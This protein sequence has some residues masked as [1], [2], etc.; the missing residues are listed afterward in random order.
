MRKVKKIRKRD[1]V[2]VIIPAFRQEK[3]IVRNIRR[4]EKALR[5]LSYPFELII[6]V[7]GMVDQT[8]SQAKKL[9]SRNIKV[10]GYESNRGKG[11]AVRYG[12]VRSKGSIIG[13][14]DSGMDINPNGLSI[15]VNELKR[16]KMDIMDIIIGSKR[17]AQSKVV[18]PMDRKILSVLSQLFIRTLFGLNVKDTQVGLKFFRREVLEDVLPR[19]LV[20]QFAFDIEIL[21]VAFHLG[22]RKIKEAPI[23]LTLN[24][25]ESIVSQNLFKVIVKTLID[26]LAIFYRLKILHYYDDTS[27]RKW[28]F[29]PELNFRINVV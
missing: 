25:T 8:F 26:T 4:I 2:S 14:I 1:L 20:K 3:T 5:A 15:P 19:L 22:Y 6:V 18:Y 17:H 27:K 28:K 23:E 12:M 29:D 16:D 21:V 24:F 9:A 7:D 10:V 11:Y 13:F